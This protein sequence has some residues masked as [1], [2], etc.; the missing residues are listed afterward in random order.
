VASAIRGKRGQR[1][2]R[3]MVAALDAMPDKRLIEGEL[4]TSEGHV[5]ALGAVGKAR[6]AKISGVDTYD[7]RALSRLFG[8]S[9]AMAA[10]IM[11]I[12]DDDFSFA[13]ETPERRFARV[14]RWIEEQLI[15]WE[16]A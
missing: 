14:R 6:G 16:T 13:N 7:R 8:I 2:L 9:Q 10:E 15:D 11:F 5:C 1:F 3:E 12:N 4:E